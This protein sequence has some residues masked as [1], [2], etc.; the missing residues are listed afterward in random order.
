MLLAN[1][2]SQGLPTVSTSGHSK[3]TSS[4]N[5]VEGSTIIIASC[6]PLLQ[7]LLEL[8]LGRRDF[9]SS[10]GWK[11]YKRYSSEPNAAHRTRDRSGQELSRQTRHRNARRQFDMESMLV[12]TQNN[13]SGS[14]ERILAASGGQPATPKPVGADPSSATTEHDL[15]QRVCARLGALVIQ[16]SGLFEEIQIVFI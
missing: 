12:T 1:L 7:P 15:R 2:Q 10:T 3:Q 4:C 13:E 5:R 9:G 6:I 8:M 14:Q 16:P 11:K